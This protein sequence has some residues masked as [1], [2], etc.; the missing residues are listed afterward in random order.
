M[1]EPTKGELELLKCQIGTLNLEH[2]NTGDSPTSCDIFE[3]TRLAKTSQK[4]LM[5]Q[6]GTLNLDTNVQRKSAA[7]EIPFIRSGR[8]VPFVFTELGVAMLSSVLNSDRAIRINISIMRVF[9]QVRSRMLM[10][11]IDLAPK[12]EALQC[13][14]AI[15]QEK[16]DRLGTNDRI[17]IDEAMPKQNN[18]R[19]VQD[20]V[21]RYFGLGVE[22]LKSQ[23]RTKAVV[24]ARQIAIFLIREN[25]PLGLAEIGNHFGQRDHT[26][27]LHACKK[28][29]DDSEANEFVRRAIKF[30]QKELQPIFA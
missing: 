19:M 13:E 27:I 5:F 15:V 17:S 4:N 6:N 3:Q 16:L 9:A 8:F 18:V 30:L 10:N 22:E 21:A 23:T 11:Q 29:H 28:I 1:F 14:L 24:L 12:L 20:R 26:T 2:L 25:L 7:A